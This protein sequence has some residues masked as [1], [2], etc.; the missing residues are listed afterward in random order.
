MN[1][2]SWK[3]SSFGKVIELYTER[4]DTQKLQKTKQQYKNHPVPTTETSN[5]THLYY[6][7]SRRRDK[8]F[9]RIFLL[10]IIAKLTKSKL[11]ENTIQ[12]KVLMHTPIK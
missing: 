4:C 9:C 11:S 2:V 5:G 6:Q 7:L 1:I 12:W 3:D 8:K 10:D